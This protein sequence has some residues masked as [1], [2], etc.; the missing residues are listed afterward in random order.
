MSRR[1]ISEKILRAWGT[2]PF[3]WAFLIC[4]FLEPCFYAS[5]KF[6]PNNLSQ[7]ESILLVGGLWVYL[8]YQYKAG[9]I[10]GRN[11][12]S[13]AL[14]IVFGDL[15]LTGLYA[16]TD[17]KA[18]WHFLGG[19]ALTAGF[20]MLVKAEHLEPE[21][22]ARLNSLL[23]MALGFWLKFY[24]VLITPI[25]KR[26]H[27]MYTF[28]RQ[29]ILKGHAGYI[30]YILQNWSLPQT[31]VTKNWGFC[32]PPLHH[33]ISAVWIWVHENIFVVGHAQ[34]RESLQTLSLFYTLVILIAAYKI[35]RYFKLT[36]ASLYIP[37][38][39]V[40]FHPAF[41][42]FSGSVNNDVL[43]TAFTV[44]SLL[45][46]LEW[47]ETKS[48][49]AAVK[50]ALCIGLGMMVKLS[51]AVIF[52][53]AAG[54]M[55]ACINK[56]NCS[57]VLKQV[58]TLGAVALPLGLWYQ[59][60]SYL[61]WG[62]PLN[63]VQEMST[64]NKQYLGQGNFLE[65]LTDFSGLSSVY[66]LFAKRLKDGSITGVNETNPILAALKNSL[67]GE[68][69]GPNSLT[70]D[71]VHNISLMFFWINA[72][73][74]VLAFLAMIYVCC[75]KCDVPYRL[76]FLFAVFYGLLVASF[77]KMAHD[78]PF[79]CTMNFRYITPIVIVSA[80][81]IGLFVRSLQGNKMLEKPLSRIWGVLAVLFAACSLTVYLSLKI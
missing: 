65:R 75:K 64:S 22:N 52:P 47:Y 18:M 45:F 30:D 2:H 4:F 50:T 40:S 80:L 49:P 39:L 66:E 55:L 33:I 36:G 5:Y 15:C 60:R 1:A 46:T 26:Q 29:G 35:F 68:S 61:K 51:A 79:V 7:L 63:Y 21:D 32:H 76:K 59:I 78:Y 3:I 13:Y 12:C 38:L 17:N 67:F 42:L 70:I 73:L 8:Y 71:F 28:D 23:I 20:Y 69:I 10:A 77:L 37:L 43:A 41:T 74:A 6:I 56:E 25:H 57:K 48:W 31:D 44:C 19:V 53:L 11:L 27:D 24:Y 16:N 58:G 81:F 54:F 72:V 9:K 62:L 34:A 14:L